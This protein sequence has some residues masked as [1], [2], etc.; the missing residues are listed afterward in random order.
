MSQSPTKTLKI[1]KRNKKVLSEKTRREKSLKENDEPCTGMAKTGLEFLIGSE[2]SNI[3]QI[4]KCL[5]KQATTPKS[6][7]T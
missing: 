5:Q 6:R 1:S 3:K 2:N 7:L 4:A